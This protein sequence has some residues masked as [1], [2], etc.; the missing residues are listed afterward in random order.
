MTS[1][2]VGALCPDSPHAVVVSLPTVDSVMR[3]ETGCEKIKSLVT[4][5]YPRFVQHKYI[6]RLQG[7]V[8]SLL[9]Q[10][11]SEEISAVYLLCSVAAARGMV[12]YCGV[13]PTVAIVA[14]GSSILAL[15]QHLRKSRTD[16]PSAADNCVLPS[17]TACK[18]DFDGL[19]T[20]L[21]SLSSSPG[22]VTSC[23]KGDWAVVL[24]RTDTDV[25]KLSM[26]LSRAKD[27]QQHTGC[28]VSSRQAEDILLEMGLATAAE[29]HPEEYFCCAASETIADSGQPTANSAGSSS[30]AARDPITIAAAEASITAFLRSVFTV[31]SVNGTA[32]LQPTIR[33]CNSGMAAFTAVF[34]AVQRMWGTT[35][36]AVHVAAN[37]A[38]VPPA[39]SSQPSS[40]SPPTSSAWPCPH[41]PAGRHRDTWLQVGWLYLDTTEV[42]RKMASTA[43]D[44]CDR[45]DTERGIGSPFTSS[46]SS[47]DGST[48][49]DSNNHNDAPS[50]FP[51][52]LLAP[53]HGLLQVM[54]ITNAAAL[55]A[56]LHRFGPRIAGV[57]TECPTNPLVQSPDI[58]ALASLVTAA[59]A[60]LVLD[61][62]MSGLSNTN[63]LPFADIV[64]LSLTKF[65]GS[66]GDVMAGAWMCNPTSPFVARTE[67]AAHACADDCGACAASDP[68]TAAGNRA[69]LEVA[70]APASASAVPASAHQVSHQRAV[71]SHSP[72]HRDLLRLAHEIAS[73]RQVVATMNESCVA[74]AR[75]LERIATANAASELP[76]AP[77]A[78]ADGDGDL[79]LPVH[80]VHWAYSAGSAS[81][82]ATAAV[83]ASSL[84]HTDAAASI[85]Q[86]P[87]LRPGSMLTLELAT[88]WRADAAAGAAATVS[89]ADHDDMQAVLAAFYDNCHIVKVGGGMQH[90]V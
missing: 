17:P 2:P 63:V 68:C 9:Q 55:T 83:T 52:G 22:E 27:Y 34:L 28:R 38:H 75:W 15:D 43:C 71:L 26:T 8:K 29:M 64:T 54:D 85:D 60:V 6:C 78:G 4:V 19:A 35:S 47:G 41:H 21:A 14:P 62:T 82:Y 23:C 11:C 31:D 50:S 70:V 5:G 90:A 59:G 24:L 25:A 12:K 80:R 45:I 30:A 67:A 61:P 42:M 76:A 1:L 51:A 73:T 20:R 44:C 66:G 87:L 49:S 53:S 18:S 46:A 10:V 81:N 40:V 86:Q 56:T 3:Y 84:L 13:P 58:S 65:S 79:R 74:V 36:G 39:A 72:Y 69:L 48:H 37:G 88:T 89:D 32:K 33:L 7:R 16:Q 57:V 77:G